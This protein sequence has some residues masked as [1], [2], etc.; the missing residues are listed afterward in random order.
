MLEFSVLSSLE[1]EGFAML[2]LLEVLSMTAIASLT[3][4]VQGFPSIPCAEA[5][6]RK[7][8]KIDRALSRPSA[9]SVRDEICCAKLYHPPI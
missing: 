4:A 6:A 3:I 1:Q 8:S 2:V 9:A 7:Y 5:A